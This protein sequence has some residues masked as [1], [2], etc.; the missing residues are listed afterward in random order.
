MER[1]TRVPK[2]LAKKKEGKKKPTLAQR[3]TAAL[4]KKKKKQGKQKS[5]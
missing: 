2:A 3:V 5:S 4:A 1:K